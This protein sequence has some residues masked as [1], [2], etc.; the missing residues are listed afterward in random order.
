MVGPPQSGLHIQ[1]QMVQLQKGKE[2]PGCGSERR[3]RCLGSAPSPPPRLR[4]LQGSPARRQAVQL[5]G[6]PRQDSLYHV[7][8]LPQEQRA[9]DSEMQNSLSPLKRARDAYSGAVKIIP[10]SA[11]GGWWGRGGRISEKH[12]SQGPRWWS[13]SS[14]V[15]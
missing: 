11:G 5:P 8:P 1:R 10:R 7:S 9:Q 15:A 13:I 14:V 12:W 2:I 3:G 4:S 6:L